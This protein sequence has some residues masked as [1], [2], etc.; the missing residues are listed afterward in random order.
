MENEK[1]K[2]MTAIDKTK[3]VLVTGATGYVA[4]WIVKKLLDEGICVHAAVRD[5]NNKEKLK[6]LDDLAVRSKGQIAYFKSDLLSDGSYAEAMEGCELVYHTASPFILD[7]KDPQKELVDPAILGTSNVL[8]TANRIESVKRVVV[9]SSVAAIYGDNIDL[10]ASV[11]GVFT[12]DDWNTSSSLTHGPYLYSKTQAEKKAWEIYSKQKRWDLVVVNPSLVMGPALNPLLV[13][14]ESFK[15][16][17]QFGD[18]TLKAGVPKMG[19]GVVDVRDLGLVHF[20]AGFVPEAKGR[21]IASGHNTSYIDLAKVLQPV[22]GSKYPIPKNEM[23][24]WLIWLLGPVINKALTRK[25][26]SRNIG[27]EWKG[28]NS[29]SKNELGLTYRLLD[30]SIVDM[31]QQLIDFKII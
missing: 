22:Y 19:M 13:T 8:E 26:V 17:K 29:K 6:F 1:C 24:T 3:P 7:V 25:F 5:P 27:Y 31:F 10:K 20:Q 14:S 30:E 9:T 15:L 21:Y 4:G 11:N 16:M 12:E 28:D 2:T 18:G 23:P